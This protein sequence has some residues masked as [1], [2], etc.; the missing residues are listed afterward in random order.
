M[1]SRLGSEGRG[2]TGAK[3]V[4]K[5]KTL[6]KGE[7]GRGSRGGSASRLLGGGGGVG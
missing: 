3:G 1:P 4:I 6:K 2:E 7:K 5:E